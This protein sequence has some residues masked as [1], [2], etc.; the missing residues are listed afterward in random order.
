M[1]R[2]APGRPRVA[3]PPSAQPGHQGAVPGIGNPS[4]S[5]PE[6]GRPVDQVEPVVEPAEAPRHHLPPTIAW[7]SVRH[8]QRRFRRYSRYPA[9][10]GTP[11]RRSSG[12]A[13]PACSPG[14]RLPGAPGEGAPA[15]SGP[16][17]LVIIW[18]SARLQTPPG[19]SRIGRR[20][21]VVL[22][23]PE[24]SRGDG[25]KPPAILPAGRRE[26]AWAAPMA[27]ARADNSLYYAG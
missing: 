23:H 4:P 8:A 19:A 25:V 18:S 9:K 10:P 3:H 6:V 15:T 22:G 24:T 13:G 11:E 26:K 5:E 14:N 7:C 21:I 2:A 12:P 27:R 16:S 17:P 20:G 1:I